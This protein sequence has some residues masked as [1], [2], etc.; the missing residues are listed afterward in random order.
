MAANG[1]HGGSIGISSLVTSAVESAIAEADIYH[2]SGTTYLHIDN[3]LKLS[4]REGDDSL[5]NS[6][7]SVV[8][9]INLATTFKQ[10]TPGEPSARVDSNSFE[11]GYGCSRA[12][13]SL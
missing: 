4:D 13:T 7:G 5:A 1:H 6:T 3:P 10:S 2:G 8:P 12:G 11:M 9:P